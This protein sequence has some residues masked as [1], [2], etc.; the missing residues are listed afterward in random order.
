MLSLCLSPSACATLTSELV[1]PAAEPSGCNQT[2]SPLPPH[3]PHPL[4][5]LV[6][7]IIRKETAVQLLRWRE[8][9]VQLP[10][11]SGSS[12]SVVRV[13]E[14][15]E[16]RKEGVTLGHDKS[17]ALA[18]DSWCLQPDCTQFSPRAVSIQGISSERDV[19]CCGWT[20]SVQESL[21]GDFRQQVRS[22]HDGRVK[23]Q[24]RGLKMLRWQCFPRRNIKLLRTSLLLPP[25]KSCNVSIFSVG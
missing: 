20:W 19:K 17:Q 16:R 6:E 10:D 12:P 24:L 11:G 18:V 2:L 25:C 1:H 22:Q 7:C 13:D 15:A 4:S 9:G 8:V 5:V 23:N 14:R 21:S 3:L